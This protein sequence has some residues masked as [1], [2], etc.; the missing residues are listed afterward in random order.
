[1]IV[2]IIMII[3]VLATDWCEYRWGCNIGLP[4][5][6]W[7]WWWSYFRAAIHRQ[8][9]G[10]VVVVVVIVV[11]TIVNMIIMV[12]VMFR[13]IRRGGGGS[14]MVRESIHGCR[15][16]GTLQLYSTKVRTFRFGCRRYRFF[17]FFF[18]ERF[19]HCCGSKSSTSSGQMIISETLGGARSFGRTEHVHGLGLQS[20]GW[21]HDTATSWRNFVT[22]IFCRNR[23]M[24]STASVA[25]SRHI[26][27]LIL[28]TVAMR[29]GQ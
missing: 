2:M 16:I 29:Y 24:T 11:I 25:R 13:I 23:M 17:F 3:I 8:A 12:G 6:W 20:V 15:S 1:M 21:Y 19:W 5:R 14:S 26:G 10:I 18:F 4:R 22:F 9:T 7:W 28:V 27:A